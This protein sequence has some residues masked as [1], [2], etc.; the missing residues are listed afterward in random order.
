MSAVVSNRI[1]QVRE[2]KGLRLVDVASRFDPPTYPAR[3]SLWENN[4]EIPRIDKVVQL[5]RI[6]GCRVDDLFPVF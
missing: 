5:A 3:V 4:H 6:L 1:K 2:E